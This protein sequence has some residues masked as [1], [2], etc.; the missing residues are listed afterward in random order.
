MVM[1]VCVYKREREREREREG[2]LSSDECEVIIIIII[3]IIIIEFLTSQLW[4]EI[5]TYPGMQ[6]S[7]GLGSV[8]LFVV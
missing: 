6:Q 1:G 5:F 7:T 3:I 2:G 4:L 8:V